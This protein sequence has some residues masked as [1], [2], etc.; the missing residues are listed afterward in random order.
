M[1]GRLCP[2]VIEAVPEVGSEETIPRLELWSQVQQPPHAESRVPEIVVEIAV[3]DKETR[4]GAVN[5]EGR[6]DVMQFSGSRERDFLNEPASNPVI[7]LLVRKAWVF[8]T[9]IAG[10]GEAPQNALPLC[11]PGEAGAKTNRPEQLW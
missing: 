11:R 3:V 1:V 10:I 8:C 7:C 5:H 4:L 9:Q 2:Q 6:A